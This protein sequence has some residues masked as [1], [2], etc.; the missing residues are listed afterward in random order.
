MNANIAGKL[1]YHHTS[2]TVKDFFI[3]RD[4]YLGMG[5]ELYLEWVRKDGTHN[6]FFDTGNGPFLEI[7]EPYPETDLSAKEDESY[8]ICFHT[9]DVDGLYARALELG[10]VSHKAPFD[11]VL[12]CKSRSITTRVAYVRGLS[13]EFIEIIS[14]GGYDYKDYLSF[15]SQDWP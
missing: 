11:N 3:S 15:V 2:F 14:W 1:V 13:G 6:C 10:A 5:L 7:H 12:H 8:H 9:E 4:F